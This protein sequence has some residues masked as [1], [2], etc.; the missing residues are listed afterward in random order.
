MSYIVEI[1][2]SACVT[3][4]L[5]IFQKRAALSA[6]ALLGLLSHSALALG[7][8]VL[9]FMTWVRI[10][11]MGLLFGEILAVSKMDRP[12]TRRLISLTR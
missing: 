4:V 8:V 5:Y 1:S 9:A 2:V 3:L 11:L 6:D 12:Q 10:D 7:L